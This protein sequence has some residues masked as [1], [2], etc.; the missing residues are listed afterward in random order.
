MHTDEVVCLSVRQPYAALLVHGIKIIELRSWRTN[1][2]GRIYIHASKSSLELPER[3]QYIRAEI[4]DGKTEMRGKIV[5]CVTLTDCRQA[6]QDDERYAFANVSKNHFAWVC[7]SPS[8]FENGANMK[9]RLG[10]FKCSDM[11]LLK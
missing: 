2:R 10:L 6:T 9:G 4:P 3:W 1:Y 7:S 8:H 11:K 5:G